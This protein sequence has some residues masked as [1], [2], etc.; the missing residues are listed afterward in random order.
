MNSP[1]SPSDDRADRDADAAPDRSRAIADWRAG[2]RSPTLSTGG[3]VEPLHVPLDSFPQSSSDVSKWEG[4]E[5]D[6]PSQPP[7]IEGLD[8]DEAADV[9]REWF[10]A[11]F[12]DPAQHTPYN[13]AEGGY[14]YIWGG[15]YDAREVIEDVFS[16]EASQEIIEAAVAAVEEDGITEWAPTD[17]RR[18]APDYEPPDEDGD[19]RRPPESSASNTPNDAPPASSPET[20]PTTEPVALQGVSAIAATGS[21]TGRA[22]LQGV[23]ATV[24]AAF[25]SELPALPETTHTEAVPQRFEIISSGGT[26]LEMK[27]SAGTAPIEINN[28]PQQEAASLQFR[29]NAEGRIDLIPDPPIADATQ[30]LLFEEMRY[31]AADLAGMGHNLLAELKGPTDRFSAALPERFEDISITRVWSRGNTLRRRLQA[32]Q[33]AMASRDEYEP[34]R[35]APAVAEMLGDLVET[36]NVFI[37][38]DPT[39]RELDQVRLTPEERDAS[40]AIVD[41]ARPIVQAVRASEQI[42]TNAA[43]QNLIEFTDAA[44]DAPA[45]VDGDQ[46]LALSRKTSGN[47]VITVLRSAYNLIARESGFALKETRAGFY[48]G[49]GGLATNAMIGLPIVAFVWEYAEALKIFVE[50]AFHNPTL[51]KIIDLIAMGPGG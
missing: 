7:N 49:L 3:A 35:L 47:F 50:R 27:P 5:L 38:G 33:I 51:I 13:S 23:S 46:A 9:I 21:L 22:V 6:R 40:E 41:A 48:R 15:P 20:N 43:I 26:P 4:P 2:R 8:V 30:N 14:Q 37:V 34:G 31:K 28:I 1:D 32:H 25:A 24:G 12:E 10:L 42:A 16:A 17:N 29:L 18:Q 45:G 39:G 11:N 44:R 36:F 19:D